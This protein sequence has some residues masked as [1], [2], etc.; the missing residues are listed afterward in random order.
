MGY[1]DSDKKKSGEIINKEFKSHEN[2]KLKKLSTCNFGAKT[3]SNICL[4]MMEFDNCNKNLAYSRG[5]ANLMHRKKCTSHEIDGEMTSITFFKSRWTDEKLDQYIPS[6]FT[7]Y[8]SKGWAY[9]FGDTDSQIAFEWADE[10]IFRLRGMS[11]VM[12]EETTEDYDSPQV[13]ALDFMIASNPEWIVPLPP[14]EIIRE[15][16]TP[17]DPECPSKKGI[18]ADNILTCLD[19]CPTSSSMAKDRER[20]EKRDK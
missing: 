18:I 16:P 19:E 4:A 11:F 12:K 1:F 15:T 5:C 2:C 9:K 10:G 20:K 6:G 8:T 17:K 13:Y 7:I 3:A 14:T